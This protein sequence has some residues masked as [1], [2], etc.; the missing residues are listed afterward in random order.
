M[1]TTKSDT[2]MP[3]T[4]TLHVQLNNCWKDNWDRFLF[5]FLSLLATSSNLEEACVP[6]FLVDHIHE[7]IDA[8]YGQLSMK[9]T[10]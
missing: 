2:A 10:T 7:D 4:P 9:L 3:L 1:N 6:F 5:C 8:S